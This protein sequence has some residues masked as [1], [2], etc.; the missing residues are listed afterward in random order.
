M[1][2]KLVPWMMLLF[3][4]VSGCGGGGGSNSTNTSP[5]SRGNTFSSSFTPD[6]VFLIVLENHGFSQVIGNPAMPYLNSLASQHALAE[7]YFANTHPSI[8]NYFMLTVGAM[9]SNNDAFAGTIADDNVVRALNASARSWKVYMESI[10]SA[11]YL[12]N[13]VYP[14]A[15]HHNPFAYLSD[16]VNS[17]AQA[18]NIV[19]FTQLASD[20]NANALPAFA[21]IAPNLLHDAHDCPG[22]PTAV[23]PDSDKLT[24]ADNWLNTNIDPLI[25]NAALA[26]SVFIIT[27][28]EAADTDATNGGG[29]IAFVAVGSHVKSGFQS[30]G[31][32]QHQ[33][34][35]HTVLDLLKVPNMPNA[36]ATAP[37]MTDFFQ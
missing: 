9:E 34:A 21:F 3:L 5:A 16:V 37:V 1:G 29:K 15:K 4:A 8:G 35:L 18:A 11:G 24:A 20:L 2:S 25:H 7:N 30:F 19:P 27:F 13:D 10:P 17:S 6:H 31:M 26:N 22:G 32:Y 14:Y 33:S 36:A 23:C 12:G 28:D